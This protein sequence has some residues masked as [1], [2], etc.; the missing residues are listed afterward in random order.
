MA[1]V[2]VFVI[3]GVAQPSSFEQVLVSALLGATLL[4]ALSVAE[5]RPPVMWVAASPSSP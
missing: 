5:V 3:E 1:I 2:V 4:L